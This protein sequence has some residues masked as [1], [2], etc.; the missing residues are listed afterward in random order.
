M[1][2]NFQGNEFQTFMTVTHGRKYVLKKKERMFSIMKGPTYAN[3]CRQMRQKLSKL[4]LTLYTQDSVYF[5]LY[6]LTYR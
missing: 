5:I 3:I 4:M 6:W 2:K 1:C